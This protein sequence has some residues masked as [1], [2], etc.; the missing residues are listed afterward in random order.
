[1]LLD[2]G[3]E[4]VALLVKDLGEPAVVVQAVVAVLQVAVILKTAHDGHLVHEVDGHVADVDDLGV[5]A[6][7]AAGLGHDCGRVGVIEHPGVGRVLLHV[8]EDLDDA[9]DGTHAVGDAAG[10]AGLLA[11]ASVLQRDLLVEL[12]HGVQAHTDVG[13]D[14]VDAGEC[15]HWVGGVGEVEL[16]RILLEVDLAG[17]G[18]DLLALG[19]VVV[20]DD[21]VHG[22][23]IVLLEEHQR[24]AGGEGGAA[25]GDGY[26]VAGL[27][28]G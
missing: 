11:H 10:A 6:Q 23:A 14:E 24:D 13:E 7:H 28:H 22:E 2:F 21:L 18:H 3:H 8:V 27:C 17:L 4:V 20:E 12:T 25:A 19:V 26:C 16:R 9:A 5:R 1:M 15:L